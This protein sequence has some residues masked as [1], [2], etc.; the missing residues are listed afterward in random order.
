MLNLF[1]LA[2]LGDKYGVWAKRQYV[3]DWIK[4]VDWK[5]VEERNSQVTAK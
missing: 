4:S 5:K 2:W 3:R 1:E